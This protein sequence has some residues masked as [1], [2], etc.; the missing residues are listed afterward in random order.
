[1]INT[2][3]VWNVCAVRDAIKLR[4]PELWVK[5]WRLSMTE[6]TPLIEAELGITL[7]GLL[8]EDA[9]RQIMKALGP[10]E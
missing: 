2:H 1:M 6:A 5:V 4:R 8:M 3:D 10:W 7:T 9:F